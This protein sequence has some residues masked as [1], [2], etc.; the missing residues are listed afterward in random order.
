MRRGMIK[1]L[2]LKIMHDD[3]VTG[4]DLMKKIEELTGRRPSSGT[5]YPML[6]NMADDG[7]IERREEGNRALYGI[8]AMGRE[9]MAEFRSLRSEYSRKIMETM[10]IAGEAF[11]GSDS[12]KNTVEF[13][14]PLFIDVREL[15]EKGVSSEKI[16]TVVREARKKLR[17][18]EEMKE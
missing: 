14:L 4:Y 6:K 11:E 9:K 12:G 13:L 10:S 8:T 18:I 5:V 17:E 2:A 1:V 3:E 7:W 15:I 16:E